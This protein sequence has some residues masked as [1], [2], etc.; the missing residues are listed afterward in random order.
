[1]N[2]AQVIVLA[3]MGVALLGLACILVLLGVAEIAFALVEGVVEGFGATLNHEWR[4]VW[5]LWAAAVCTAA[6]GSLLAFTAYSA[7][8]TIGRTL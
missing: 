8:N 6:P 4:Y 1:M 3:L 2:E 5:Q 7:A